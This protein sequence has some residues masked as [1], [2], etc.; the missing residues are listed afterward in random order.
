MWEGE[1]GRVGQAPPSQL[2]QLSQSSQLSYHPQLFQ[3]SQLSQSSQKPIT[4]KPTTMSEKGKNTA[5]IIL[6]IIAA[7]ATAILGVF[8]VSAAI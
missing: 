7:I 3:S 1:K 8:G 4:K 6:K 5:S 2:S